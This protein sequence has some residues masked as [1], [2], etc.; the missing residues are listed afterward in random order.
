MFY[1][2]G[3][4]KVLPGIEPG[5]TLPREENL[6]VQYYPKGCVEWQIGKNIRETIRRKAA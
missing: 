6:L 3:I 4:S 1:T 2:E 5:L